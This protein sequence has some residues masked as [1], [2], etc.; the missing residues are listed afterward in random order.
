M[1]G[2]VGVAKANSAGGSIHTISPCTHGSI[3]KT[4]ADGKC[5]YVIGSNLKVNQNFMDNAETNTTSAA[6][7]HP[8]N[9]GKAPHWELMSVCVSYIL[10]DVRTSPLQC[11]VF[12]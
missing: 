8:L 10:I 1:E 6:H 11:S 4:K 12:F 5:V 9:G 2:N 7:R 3:L